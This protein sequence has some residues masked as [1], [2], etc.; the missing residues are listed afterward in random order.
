MHFHLGSLFV[1]LVKGPRT[2]QKTMDILYRFVKSL[3][4]VP[5]V[6]KKE[7]AGY[8]YN[9]IMLGHISACWSM[10]IDHAQRIEDLDRAWMIF[11]REEVGPFGVMDFLGINV[12][13]DGNKNLLQDPGRRDLAQRTL[14]FLQA[15]IDRGE[16]GIK[17]GKGFYTYPDPAYQNPNFLIADPKDDQRYQAM[18]NGLIIEALVLVI[19][20]VASVEEVNRI[21]ML[22]KN[23]ESGPFT[24]LDNKGIEKFLWEIKNPVYPGVYPKDRLNDIVTFLNT[25]LQERKNS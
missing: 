11:N 23:S 1:D 22:V 10:V 13:F 19:D 21:W 9:A 5:H 6:H 20:D 12:Y 17:T 7:N 2:S 8:V 3:T 24:W 25:L 18:L 16:L 15:F 4:C 14:D